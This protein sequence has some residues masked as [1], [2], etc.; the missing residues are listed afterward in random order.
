[1]AHSLAFGLI[2]A[3]LACAGVLAQQGFRTRVDLVRLPVVVLDADGRPVTGLEAAD[4]DVLED[5]TA[6]T[7][8]SFAAGAPGPDVPLHVGLMLDKSESMALDL[9]EAAEAAVSFVDTL[10]EI[11]DV[12]LVEFDARIRISRFTPSSYLRLFERIRDPTMGERTVLYDAIAH[13]LDTTVGRQ[14][15]H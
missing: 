5:G 11:R 2:G 7:V 9:E 3:V 12:T 13:Y 1:M 8:V 14:G 15:Q 4:F 10:E 6:Q